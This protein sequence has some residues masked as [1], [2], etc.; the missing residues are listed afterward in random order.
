[1]IQYLLGI[2]DVVYGGRLVVLC[3]HSSIFDENRTYLVAVNR[4]HSFA[5]RREDIKVE[6]CALSLFG[7]R[8]F[9]FLDTM[10][11]YDTV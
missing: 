2:R 11:R 6:S 3:S 9:S 7:V 1:M 10:V 4:I 5:G 8:V